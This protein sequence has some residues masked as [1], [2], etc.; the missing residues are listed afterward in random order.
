MVSD[1][2]SLRLIQLARQVI[3]NYLEEGK[4]QLYPDSSSDLQETQGA[5]VSVYVKE[6]LR[7]CIGHIVSDAPLYQ[8]VQHLAIKSITQD[9]R[10]QPLAKSELDHLDIEISILTPLKKVSDIGEIQIGTHGLYLE[11]DRYSGLLLPQVATDHGWELDEFLFH[12]CRKA[13]LAPNDWQF[14][15]LYCFEAQVF[16][17]RFPKK[18][19]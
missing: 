14:G 1:N 16:G 5:F 12:L 3:K 18:S 13:G 7:G 15:E 11:K 19:V 4:W 2:G 10:F 17:S 6:Q 9:Y 8:T